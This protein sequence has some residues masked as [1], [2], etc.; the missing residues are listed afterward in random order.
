MVS[1][2]ESREFNLERGTKQGDP[3]SSA[4]FNAVLESIMRDLKSKWKKERLGFKMGSH[5]LTNLRFA[6][7]ILLFGTSRAQ[8]RRM[9]KY[10][11][12]RARAAGLKLHMGKTKIL[13]NEADRRGVLRQKDVQVGEGRVEVLACGDST[14]YLGRQL[15]FREYHDVEINHRISRG[16][17]A[18]GKFKTELCNRHYLLQSIFKLFD[19]VVSSTVLYGSGAWTLTAAREQKLNA[20]MRK[21]LRKIVAVSRIE[22]ESYVDW[23]VRAT[24]R[25]EEEYSRAGLPTW[26]QA[27][28]VRKAS[29]CH[30]LQSCSDQRWGQVALRWIPSGYRSI[31]RPP[32]RWT[33]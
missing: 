28:S 31:G 23:I 8:V 18:F 7:D 17:A 13:S 5:T 30:K 1:D 22:E 20:T 15:T 27:Q 21:M 9:L 14:P 12:E 3:M 26:L 24:R 19:A 10:L 6:D 32:K 16:W 11:D 4:L 25:A 29:L 33:D 2:R